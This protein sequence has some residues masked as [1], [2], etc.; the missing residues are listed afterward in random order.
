MLSRFPLFVVLAWLVLPI[1][2]SAEF[3]TFTNSDG[4]S[5]EAQLVELKDGKVVTIE[6]RNGRELDADLTA[7]SEADRKHIKKWWEQV[8]K[9]Q[10]TLKPRNRLDITVKMNRKAKSD[11]YHG[12]SYADDETQSFFPEVVIENEEL[13]TFEGN[14]VRIVILA[15]DARN[16]YQMLVVSATTEEKVRL[17]ERSEVSIEGKPFRLRKYEYRYGSTNNYEY[18]YEYDGYIVVV[19]NREGVVTHTKA[20]KSKFLSNMEL[21]NSCK[22]GEMYDDSFTRKLNTKPNSY[23]V[24]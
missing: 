11:R 22:A 6:L 12:W 21:V 15:N 14:T 2:A 19:T 3:R 18:G 20:S 8:Q 17:P 4:V 10:V 5:I 9:D 7:F 13:D 1:T 24:E 16:D 23:Y